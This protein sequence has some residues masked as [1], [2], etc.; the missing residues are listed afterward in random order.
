MKY[1]RNVLAGRTTRH[2]GKRILLLSVAAAT[3]GTAGTAQD[4]QF[5][6]FRHGLWS[7]QRTTDAPRG[8][9]AAPGKLGAPAGIRVCGDPAAEI[10]KKMT[11]LEARRCAFSAITHDGNRYTWTM[12]CPVNGA[13]MQM[14]SVLTVVSDS[15][16]REDLTSRWGGQ[17]SKSVLSARRLGDCTG[18]PN[19]TRAGNVATASSSAH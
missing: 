13:V 17:S 11:Q 8:A 16:Y 14:Q 2:I 19:P 5:P 4:L 1:S 12:E 3:V 7:Y 10:K 6:P 15:A 9:L 18:P